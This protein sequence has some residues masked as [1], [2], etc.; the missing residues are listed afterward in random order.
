MN[1][2]LQREIHKPVI[3][4]VREQTSLSYFARDSYLRQSAKLVYTL[5]GYNSHIPI[6]IVPPEAERVN[7]HEYWPLIGRNEQTTLVCTCCLIVSD[8]RDKSD[9]NDVKLLALAREA[10]LPR[11]QYEKLK[12]HSRF[13]VNWHNT[14]T[15]A[16]HVC[17]GMIVQTHAEHTQT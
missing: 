12:S 9:V 8:S 11:L 1:C 5:Q 4:P 17:F 16:Y 7:T 6:S 10:S 15:V 3:F 13:L 2:P 14:S